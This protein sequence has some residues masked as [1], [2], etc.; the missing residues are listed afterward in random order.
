MPRKSY[1]LYIFV[2]IFSPLAFGAVEEWSLAVMEAS[3]LLALSLFLSRTLK[4]KDP[5]YETP[6][7]FPLALFLAYILFQLVPLPPDLIKILSPKTYDIYLRTVWQ[8][9]I[10]WAALSLNRK[11]TLSEFFRIASYAAFYVLTIQLLARKDLLKKTINIVIALVSLVSLQAM[12]QLLVSNK[13][14]FWIREVSE[15]MQPFGPYINRNHFAGLMEMIFPLILGLFLFYKPRVSYGSFGE[16]IA[17]MFNQKRM[18]MYMVLGFSA[19]L[20]AT[21]IFVSLSR[22]GILSLCLAMI[23]FA[24]IFS[25]SRLHGKKRGLIILVAVLIVVAVGWFGWDSVIKRFGKLEGEMNPSF[26]RLAFW[27]DTAKIAGDF[28]VTGT[29]LGTFSDIYPKYKSFPQEAVLE[30]AHNDYLELAA[31]GGVISIALLA[32]FFLA[33]AFKS[34]RTFRKRRE[35]WSIVMAIGGMSGLIAIMAHGVTDFNSHVGANGLYIFFLAGLAVSASHT[36]LN[37]EAIDTYL[38]GRKIPAHIYGLAIT[39]LAVNV[40]FS[41]GVI[42][43]KI[44]YAFAKNGYEKNPTG[45]EGLA[46]LRSGFRRASFFDPLDAGYKYIL[47][48][49][50]FLMSD[51]A[52]AATHCRQAISLSPADGEY[53]QGLGLIYSDPK[54]PEIADKWLRLGIDFDGMDAQRYRT[55]ASWLF[56][57]ERKG[58]ALKNINTALSLVPERTK[59][60]IALMLLN[61]VS[62][63]EIK[64]SLPERTASFLQFAD[65]LEKTADGEEEME[66]EAYHNA[67]QYLGSEKEPDPS[68]FA[69]IYRY[70]MKKE[71]YDDALN[72]MRLAIE[73]LPENADMRI[74][75]AAVYEKLGIV[76]RAK[77]EYGRALVIDPL[78]RE[79]R[80]KLDNLIEHGLGGQEGNEAGK[81]D[82]L[83]R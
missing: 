75:A 49:T 51:N 18:N 54:R 9:G 76:Y 29:G 1:F 36:R 6:G 69:R 2:L 52:N 32:W 68:Y 24:A 21:S 66:D 70:Y 58:L 80:L 37:G 19:V 62:D 43:G 42:T 41:A 12:M 67:F 78:N 83:K 39:L 14:I 8:E 48:N 13:K 22:G 30:H 65:Y 74:S 77:E 3:S 45:K 27:Q 35:P 57:T 79:A 71:R 5:L 23:F 55:Y 20:V 53:H 26:S 81:G 16:R 15:Y 38:E 64:E 34:F 50:E 7:I 28:P 82:F 10:S 63:K 47:A 44:Q 73:R 33:V 25:F 11:A 56:S 4:R 46:D 31:E 59:E 60:F 61:D 40:V 17:E 72:V